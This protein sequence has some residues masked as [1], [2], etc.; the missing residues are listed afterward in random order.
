M[1]RRPR[2]PVPGGQAP[3]RLRGRTGRRPNPDA[4]V[5]AS[6]AYPPQ[7]AKMS[8]SSAIHV[9]PLPRRLV[10]GSAVVAA[11]VVAAL[12]PGSDRRAG[13][14]L[15]PVDPLSI[16]APA[17]GA[18]APLP[19]SLPKAPDGVPP[20]SDAPLAAAAP[21]ADAAA[22]D[23]ALPPSGAEITIDDKGIRIEKPGADGKRSRRITVRGATELDDR[24]VE[25]L[26]HMSKFAAP[27]AIVA[28]TLLFVAPLLAIALV[29][30]YKMRRTRM[31]NETLLKFAERGI[32]PPPQAFEALGAR[33][34]ADVEIAKAALDASSRGGQPIAAAYDQARAIGRQAAMSDL[35]KGVFATAIG[36]GFV[37]YSMFENGNANVFGL[38]VLFVGIGYLVLWH[39]EDRQ[40]RAAGGGPVAPGGG[41]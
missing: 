4:A 3:E 9:R 27:V 34:A 39:F 17:F 29:I 2:D 25:A 1:A 10:I 5:A 35:R 7:G 20:R 11:L 28:V 12:S 24:D 16:V 18:D 22:K 8:H 21:R 30:W 40:T 38:V 13:R 36:L 41:L 32:A 19:P 14:G 15:D 33:R 23:E 37:L 6:K 31:L 26:A